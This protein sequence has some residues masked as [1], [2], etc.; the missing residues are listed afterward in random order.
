M[1]G[2]IG[3][4]TGGSEAT[5][6]PGAAPKAPG[7]DDAKTQAMAAKQYKRAQKT[8]SVARALLYESGGTGGAPAPTKSQAAQL[9]AGGI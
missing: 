4:L 5:A 6:T 3:G 8:N 2:L 1:S 9:M 7:R